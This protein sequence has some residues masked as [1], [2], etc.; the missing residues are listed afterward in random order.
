MRNFWKPIDEFFTEEGIENDYLILAAQPDGDWLP[1]FPAMGMDEARQERLEFHSTDAAL[2]AEPYLK[3]DLSGA[4]CFYFRIQG[5]REFAKPRHSLQDLMR[6]VKKTEDDHKWDGAVPEDWLWLEE[7]PR[8]PDKL[9]RLLA[10]IH[11]EVSEAL[12]AVRNNDYLE[13][14]EELAD[15]AIRLFTLSRGLGVNLEDEILL[16]NDKNVKREIKHGG[17]IF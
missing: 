9:A 7:K 11:S 4:F 2:D 10:L 5:P 8:N 14:R 13:F 6:I 1:L 12:E 3:E 17:K 16:K 15:I